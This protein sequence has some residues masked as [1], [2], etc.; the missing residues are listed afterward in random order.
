MSVILA[1]ALGLGIFLYGMHQ[2]ELGLQTLGS[3]RVKQWLGRSTQNP[4]S[5][6]LSGTVITAILQ[7]SS[8]VSLI[9]LAFASAGMI[10]LFNAV[11]VILGANLGTTFTG[12]VV[13]TIGFKMDL[14]AFALPLFGLAALVQVFSNRQSV[15]H[16]IAGIFL[17][18]GLLLFG[19]VQMKDA[20]A[21]L[22]SILSPELL[23][24]M[25]LPVFL[26]VGMA[27]TAVIQSSSAM[28]MIAL[29]ALNSGFIDL[30]GAAALVVGADIGT[31]S[32]TALGSLKGAPVAKQLALAHLIYN[33][34]V[35]ALAF[36]LMIPALPAVLSFFG[37]E[38]PL[39]GLVLFHSSFNLLGLFIF[40]PFLKQYS[41]W[42]SGFFQRAPK[43]VTHYLHATPTEVI[44]A[45]MTALRKELE[46]L[47][48]K[49]L[50]LNLRNLKLDWDALKLSPEQQHW[51]EHQ[52]DAEASFE[53]RYVALKQLEGAMHAYLAELQA[54]KLNAEQM[55]QFSLIM[56]CARDAIYSAKT[57]KD[58]RG[59]LVR[60]RHQSH[61]EPQLELYFPEVLTQIYAEFCDILLNSHKPG[62]VE[63]RLATLR[64][65]NESLHEQLHEIIMKNIQ[66][67]RVEYRE[68]SSL[69][70]SNRELWHSTVNMINAMEHRLSLPAMPGVVF[71]ET[72]EN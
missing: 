43:P 40:V 26:L 45:A 19:L 37:I 54:R 49:S 9:V 21:D 47:I 25:S 36:V 67:K 70:N 71:Q 68:L 55:Q 53:E 38:D 28:T 31:T 33:L 50:A 35:D 8:M 39:Y 48:A 66:E 69:L 59:D 17:G 6:V 30:S 23:A 7:S 16:A 65:Q 51:L 27:M 5:S 13:A 12:W 62:Y 56:H 46:G 41:H 64:R 72:E 2:L 29:T 58:V 60:F 11:G 20:V 52:F 42:L 4:L 32:T 1:L 14:E 34:F 44:E 15:Q 10:P 3:D 22:P 24:E 63:Q 18:L 57:L 61:A